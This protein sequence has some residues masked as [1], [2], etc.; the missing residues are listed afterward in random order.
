MGSHKGSS[1]TFNIFKK[2]TALMLLALVAGCGGSGSGGGPG[3][4]SGGSNSGPPDDTDPSVT[5][6]SPGEDAAGIATN[7]KLTATFS[8]AMDPALITAI[9][10]ATGMPEKFRLTDG[11]TLPDGVTLILFPGTV[12]YDSTNHIAVFRPTSALDPGKR[13]TATIITGIKDL[14]NNPLTTD[15][16][17]CFTTGGVTDTT[18]PTVSS[19]VPG[20]AATGV[21]TNHKV[22]ATFSEEMNSST[23][24]PANFTLTGTG[25]SAI[26]GTVTY[27]D[28][29]AIF[30]P[31]NNL[32][33]STPYTVS[34]ATGITD[35]VG[36][37]VPA[38]TWSFTTG[39]SPDVTAPVASS[40]APVN[41]ELNVATGRTINVSFNE[42]MD[43]ATIT[44]ANFLVAGLGATPIIGTVSF[45]ASNNTATFTR[46]NH[47]TTPVTFHPTPMSN[48]DLS[49]TYTA[50]LTTGVKDMAGNPLANSLVWSFTTAP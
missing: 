29:M 18:A 33:A 49:T 22:I 20:N 42:P 24:T 37:A 25:A 4:A 27:L 9:D 11:T 5:A 30:M 38:N 8:E 14:G 1:S 23:L 34:F 50:T 15:F 28:R 48:L 31:S 17:W 32:A 10:P 16:A 35:V 6:M 41:N 40:T 26:S 43:P 47:L 36:N 13:Y 44:T 21:P 2:L 19:R 45:D 39:A 3:S 46:I 12:S 7:S